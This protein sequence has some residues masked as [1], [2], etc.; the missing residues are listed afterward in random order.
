MIEPGGPAER[1]V[2]LWSVPALAAPYLPESIRRIYDGDW[3]PVCPSDRPYLYVNFVTSRDGRVSFAEP[4]ANSAGPISGFSAAD[5]WLMGL[6]R[7]GCD[8]VLVGDGT[9]RAEPE[10]IW[11]SAHIYP[12]DAAAFA[13]LRQHWGLAPQPVQIILS[14]DGA[15]DPAAAI[16]GRSDLTVLV[17]TTDGGA[18]RARASLAG[19][20]AA[21][22]VVPCGDSQVLL[23]PLMQQLRHD[24]GVRAL[25]CEGGPRVYG[26]L[27]A[28]RLVDDEFLT[29]SPLMAGEAAGQPRPSLVEGTAFAPGRTP[30]AE[31]L[32]LRRS[33]EYLFL[34]SRWHYDALGDP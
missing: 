30:R 18:V 14:L 31:L 25:L 23:G 27:L 20:A 32:A 11:T 2:Q 9:L 34:H 6:L 22:H 15:L 24:H 10:H 4:G 29:L 7:A 19:S 5:R 3:W 16:F 13:A 26:A 12:D 1:F 17:A 8:A 21:V 33:G 28:A